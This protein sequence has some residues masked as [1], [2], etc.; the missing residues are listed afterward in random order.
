MFVDIVNGWAG[1]R[2]TEWA[3]KQRKGCKKR[4]KLYQKRLENFGRIWYDPVDKMLAIAAGRRWS[5][6]MLDF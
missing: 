4:Q 6:F 2:S 3:C 1:K 5:P